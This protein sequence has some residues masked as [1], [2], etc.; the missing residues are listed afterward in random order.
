[1]AA[2]EIEEADSSVAVTVADARFMKPLDIDLV[3]S[4]AADHSAIVTV[5]ENSIGGFG[6]S[7]LHFLSLEGLLDSG[8]L[9]FRPMVLPDAYFEAGP[10]YEQYENAGLNAKHIRGTVMRLM[11]KAVVP[12]LLDA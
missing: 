3:R 9:K 1:M 8:D 10:Q 4:L 11:G 5:E 6:D 12:Q 7:V 2:N